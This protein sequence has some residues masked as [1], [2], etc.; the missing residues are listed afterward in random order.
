MY[1]V[2]AGSAKPSQNIKTEMGCS[3]VATLVVSREFDHQNNHETNKDE[4]KRT[5]AR[6]TT[7]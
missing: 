5:S 3:S 7:Q 4:L 1:I 2:S 6:T